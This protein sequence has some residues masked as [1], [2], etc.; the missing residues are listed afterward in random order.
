MST[1]FLLPGEDRSAAVRRRSFQM[2]NVY[3]ADFN[4]GGVARVSA[5]EPGSII[6]Y[7]RILTK[8][9]GTLLLIAVASL[10][11]GFLFTKLQAPIYRARTL[12]EIES[13]ND[14]FLHVRD[15][16]SAGSDVS[17]Q[18]PESN[19][20]TQ[21]AVLQSRPV[22]ERTLQKHNLWSRMI[23]DTRKR[24]GLIE[25]SAKASV[26]ETIARA[27]VVNLTSK[28]LRIRSQPNTRVLEITFDSKDP[29]IAADFV[30]SL[31]SAFTEVTFENRLKF[32]QDTSAWLTRHIQDVKGQVQKAEGEL[33]KY[34]HASDL[35]F[36]SEA[37]ADTTVQARMRE[38]QL[39]LSR[40]EEDRILKQSRYE[41]AQQ[42]PS[43]SLPEVLDSSTLRDYHVQ[44][45]QLRQQL[46]DLSSRFT[47][48]Y[49]KVV[50]TQAQI[51][52]VQSAL[53]R[54]RA[55]TL[56]RTKNEYESASRRE[57]LLKIQYRDLT[58]LMSIQADKL[59]H[60]QLLKQEVATSHKL[61]DV[62]TQRVKEADL[63]SAMRTSNIHVIEAAQSPVRPYQPVASLDM[64]F[65][66][67][68]GLGLGCLVL[69]QR[70]RS[71]TRIQEPGDTPFELNVPELGIIPVGRVESPSKLRLLLR[72]GGSHDEGKPE[73]STLENASSALAESFRLTLTSILLCSSPDARPSVLALSSAQ[74]GEGKTTVVTNLAIAM[75]RM[76][77]RVLLIDGDL[78]KRRLHRI[79][80]TDNNNGLK[81][82]LLAASKPGHTLASIHAQAVEIP[83][84][85]NLFLLPSGK[86]E[87]GEMLFFTAQLRS[88]LQQLKAEFDMILIDT[89][90]LLQVADA[91]LICH[92][93]DA[94]ILVVAQ[95][96]PREMA[97]LARQKL[98]DDGSRLL[99][100]ILNKYDPKSS[101]HGYENYG[102][103]YSDYYGR[104]PREFDND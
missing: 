42:A 55:N 77:R 3:A 29:Q 13:I 92:E 31:S 65:G 64:A 56:A 43:D 102:N 26:P 69:I 88:F 25:R 79:F 37:E 33:Q 21:I 57:N 38:M 18:S 15:V 19:V 30:N 53:D 44:L 60:Y 52:T 17:T 81:E 27:E 96:T 4:V 47:P 89:P 10:L 85:S 58:A 7:W 39:E 82:A 87:A 63:D 46:A 101:L 73:L 84:I 54:E 14:D 80:K 41:L 45:T 98:A 35:T 5:G 72:K 23:A 67:V 103:Y 20:R 97:L 8:R 74:A 36:T 2:P 11:A 59:S 99:G 70:A 76:N 28:R 83:H 75:S 66:L 49:P 48:D 95:H 50:S 24:H 32:T 34:A 1:N 93:A 6:E 86:G 90:P 68:S 16:N 94:C 78:R 40:A 61:Y 62:L 9:K 71:N 100:T 22:I 51:K 12:V 91:R 104:S